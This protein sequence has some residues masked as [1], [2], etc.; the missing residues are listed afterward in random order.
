MACKPNCA[1]DSGT[2]KMNTGLYRRIMSFSL[3][4]SYLE[5]HSIQMNLL[6]NNVAYFV[7]ID[8]LKYVPKPLLLVQSYMCAFWLLK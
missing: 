5:L 1:L 8:T 4:V 3:F 6:K 7:K 2:W